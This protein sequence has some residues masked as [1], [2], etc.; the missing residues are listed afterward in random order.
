MG[1]SLEEIVGRHHSLFCPPEYA[2][3]ADYRQFW[4]RLRQGDFLSQEFLRVGKSGRKAIIDA[5]YNPIFDPDGRVVKVVKFA[6]DVTGR[7]EDVS[8]LGG[9]MRAFSDSDLT[10]RVS[11]PFIP[12][13]E[14]LKRHYNAAATSFVPS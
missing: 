9:G 11:T 10:V 1:Y 6:T 5:S 7:V 2:R 14:E 3:S 4:D 12:T 13:L 8:A